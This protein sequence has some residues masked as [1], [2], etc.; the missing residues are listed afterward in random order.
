MGSFW[1]GKWFKGCVALRC[2]GLFRTKDDFYRDLKGRFLL[3]KVVFCSFSFRGSFKVSL[4]RIRI[5]SGSVDR[6]IQINC[7]FR[8]I[9]L[10][11]YQ[12][13]GLD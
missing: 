9:T 8:L 6:E 7:F 5:D 2:D 1:G 3:C 11:F 12:L 13:C 4:S 10:F